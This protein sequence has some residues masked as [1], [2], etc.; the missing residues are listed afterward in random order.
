MSRTRHNVLPARERPVYD[1]C[2]ILSPDGVEMC[3]VSEKRARWYLRR[4][5]ARLVSKGP[6]VIRLTFQP[7]GHGHAGDIFYTTPRENHC[8]VCGETQ[9]LSR[10]HVVPRW[11]RRH[12]PDEIKGHSSH[13]LL[14][15]CVPCHDSYERSAVLLKKQLADEHNAPFDAGRA[16]YNRAS[17]NARKAAAALLRK[18]RDPDLRIPES[19]VLELTTAVSEFID[20]ENPSM[21]QIERLSQLPTRFDTGDLSHGQMV[22]GRVRDIQQFVERWRR[23]FIQTLQPKHMPI[24]WAVTRAV[25]TVPDD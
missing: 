25:S 16:R 11:Y 10:H 14:P 13:D 4:D 19:R 3:R 12:F 24:G 6:L 20:V 2:L 7:R 21:E 8:V 17:A 15:L 1:G 22:V 9:G 23:H 18:S 5:L